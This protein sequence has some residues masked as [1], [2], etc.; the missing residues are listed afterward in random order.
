MDGCLKEM[1]SKVVNAGA[2]LRL[3]GKVWSVV[4]C[5]LADDTVLLVEIE[6]DLQRV[7][8]EFCS[9]WKRRKLKVN[10]GKSMIMV[11]ERR[12]EEEDDF[13]IAYRA[14]LPAVVRCENSS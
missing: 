2:K 8:N 6:G 13:N 4:T 10:A 3:N 1:K 7:V 5:V 12:K 11:F 14:R 9:V